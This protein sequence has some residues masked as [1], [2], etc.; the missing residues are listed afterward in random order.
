MIIFLIFMAKVKYFFY[1][2]KYDF[3]FSQLC[4][5]GSLFRR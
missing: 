2:Q 4:R 5:S 1:T 3:T